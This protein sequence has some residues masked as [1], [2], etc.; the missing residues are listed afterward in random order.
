MPAGSATNP[1]TAES[2]GNDERQA[3]AGDTSAA[4]RS[5]RPHANAPLRKLTTG[6][7]STYKLI[8]TKYYEAKKARSKS[9]KEDYTAV[10]GE[11]LGGRY[12]VEESLG[13][14]SFGQVVSATDIKSGS[15]VAVKVIKNKDAFRR[16][17]KTEIRILE[18]LNRKDPEDQ[19]CIGM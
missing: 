7:L 6:L 16:Q 1:S 2:S 11:V 10:V 8:N 5:V 13:K 9:G 3:E 17:A 12:R 19:W 4:P 18:S 14:G 15:T